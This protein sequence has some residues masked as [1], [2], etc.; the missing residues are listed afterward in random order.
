M[1]IQSITCKVDPNEVDVIL[2]W[3]EEQSICTVE[4]DFNE[5]DGVMKLS[6]FFAVSPEDAAH[7]Q[8]WRQFLA[9]FSQ[10]SKQF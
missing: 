6:P 8:R 9:Q 10:F 5:E 7:Q 2:D 4:I 3:I 1:Q